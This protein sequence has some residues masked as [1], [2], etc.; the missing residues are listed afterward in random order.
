MARRSKTADQILGAALARFND[1]GYATTTLA[2]I[3]ASVDISQGNLTYHFPTKRD[4]VTGIQEAVAAEIAQRRTLPT[5]DAIEDRYVEH[6]RFMMDVTARYR[7][8]LRDDA[9]IEPGPDHETPHRVLV[10]GH[11]TLRR[12]LDGVGDHGLFRQDLDVDL[13]VLGRALW[14][15]ERYWMEYLNEMEL[16]TEIGWEDQ[17]RG[18]EHHFA[19]LLPNLTAEGRRRFTAALARVTDAGGAG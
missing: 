16:R 3:A 18:I 12:L 8:L 11:A 7:F 9:H 5:P 14:V 17:R 10:D 2:E 19:V 6:L 15:L 13:D 1:R 4:L